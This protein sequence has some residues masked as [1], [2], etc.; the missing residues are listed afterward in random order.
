M[1]LWEKCGKNMLFTWERSFDPEMALP[2]SSSGKSK[3][4]HC[5]GRQLT[6]RT[7]SPRLVNKGD[8]GFDR[9]RLYLHHT[10]Q[11]LRRELKPYRIG[12]LFTPNY[13][14]L[15]VISVAEQSCTAPISK[16]ERHVSDRFNT[17]YRC[18]LDRYLDG[19]TIVE[20][21]KEERGLEPTGTEVIFGSEDWDFFF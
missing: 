18:S 20:M 3:E 14:D 19:C 4:I 15:G 17:F 11:L 2:R 9:L 12:L 5:C 8:S 10:G 21:N 7:S 16:A 13:G 1:S 6:D